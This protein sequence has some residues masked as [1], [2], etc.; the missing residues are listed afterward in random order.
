LPILGP[1]RRIGERDDEVQPDR[2]IDLP[3]ADPFHGLIVLH[4]PEME[5][6]GKRIIVEAD[7]P[8]EDAPHVF[9]TAGFPKSS[10]RRDAQRST[11]W[12]CSLSEQ[13]ARGPFIARFQKMLAECADVFAR[14]LGGESLSLIAQ[15]ITAIAATG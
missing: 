6:P 1:G 14:R 11:G 2:V 13:R 15:P 5:L 3:L 9:A 8:L 12:R 4:Q 7:G 10:P